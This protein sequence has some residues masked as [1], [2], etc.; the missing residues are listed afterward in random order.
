MEDGACGTSHT[1]YRTVLCKLHRVMKNRVLGYL[2]HR[3]AEFR[4]CDAFAAKEPS[5][6]SRA[7]GYLQIPNSESANFAYD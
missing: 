3:M 1:W 7:G 6:F 4:G 5:R 2:L